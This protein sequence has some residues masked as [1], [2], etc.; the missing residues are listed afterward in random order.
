MVKLPFLERTVVGVELFPRSIRWVEL[1]VLFGRVSLVSY[2]EAEHPLRR[3]QF[4]QMKDQ[5]KADAYVVSVVDGALFDHMLVEDAPAI[6]SVVEAEQWAENRNGEHLDTHPG[7]ECSYTVTGLN[8]DEY[9][10]FFLG[11]HEERKT[12]CIRELEESDVP[13][14]NLGAG[15]LE[16]SYNLLLNPDVVTGYSAVLYRHQDEWGLVLY[17][18]GQISQF[19]PLGQVPDD[20]AI[21]LTEG[22]LTTEELG[23]EE[24]GEMYTLYTYD[25][26]ARS[27]MSRRSVHSAETL[28]GLKIGDRPPADYARC[29]GAAIKACFPDI[30]GFSFTSEE[31][32]RRGVFQ[33]DQKEALRLGILLFVPIICVMLVLYGANS[34]LSSELSETTQI[35]NRI[36]ENVEQVEFEQ[37]RALQLSRSFSEAK[38]LVLERTNRSRFFQVLEKAIIDEVWIQG[39]MAEGRVVR[40]TGES[41]SQVGLTRFMMN[42]ESHVF[43]ESVELVKSDTDGESTGQQS[44]TSFELLVQTAE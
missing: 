8:E 17:Q 36:K 38:N 20:Q 35:M 28:S 4:Q 33:N 39:L 26:P 27:G 44:P 1:N 18:S 16:S 29:A 3:E 22:Y 7:L 14:V 5:L 6:D 41:G 31:T 23:M 40:V 9:R 24:Q 12:Q 34:I 37:E 13:V 19:Y 30:D 32:V 15:V 2:G 43:T 21:E 11:I 25:L 42:L 10:G